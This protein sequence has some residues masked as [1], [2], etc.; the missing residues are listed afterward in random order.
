MEYCVILSRWLYIESHNICKLGAC[1]YVCVPKG[2]D[3]KALLHIDWYKFATIKELLL[4]NNKYF[5]FYFY[6]LKASFMLCHIAH[7]LWNK[8]TYEFVYFSWIYLPAR[9][10]ITVY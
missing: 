6:W 7:M 9:F 4:E 10:Q 3:F 8:F 1:V 2:H 5:Y